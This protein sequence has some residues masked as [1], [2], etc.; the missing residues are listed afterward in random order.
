MLAEKFTACESLGESNLNLR[1]CSVTLLLSQCHGMRF[2]EWIQ[3]S[4]W[5]VHDS[6]FQNE[7]GDGNGHPRHN[8]IQDSKPT[9]GLHGKYPVEHVGIDIRETRKREKCHDLIPRNDCWY[10]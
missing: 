1:F 2:N 5:S 7:H 8:S 3:F 6:I 9:T 10:R 4:H